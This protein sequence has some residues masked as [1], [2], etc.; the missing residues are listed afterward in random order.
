MPRWVASLGTK[1][2]NDLVVPGGQYNE[3]FKNWW[4]PIHNGQ[5]QLNNLKD[6]RNKGDT[7]TK[8]AGSESFNDIPREVNLAIP[9]KSHKYQFRE[10][11][12]RN[13]IWGFFS[14]PDPPNKYKKWDILL[15][16]YIFILDWIKHHVKSIHKG[17][18]SDEYVVHNMTWSGVYLGSTLS[19]ALLQKVF[20]FVPLAATWP[21]FYVT[22]ITTF[23]SGSYDAL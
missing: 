16:Q 15:Q 4:G 14:L 23:F 1:K 13:G 7:C 8:Y 2:E 18:K 9:I 5:L 20:T 6:K 11:M 10:H 22:T 12:L 17:S 21:G 19:N 3:Y